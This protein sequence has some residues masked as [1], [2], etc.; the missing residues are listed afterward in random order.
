MSACSISYLSTGR[1]DDATGLVRTR[2][3]ADLLDLADAL[4]DRAQAERPPQL[5][6][7]LAR[8]TGRLRGRRQ[9]HVRA[10]IRPDEHV[11]RRVERAVLVLREGGHPHL[12]GKT[13][14]VDGAGDGLGE[15]LGCHARSP[16][17]AIISA[18]SNPATSEVAVNNIVNAASTP[19]T[20]F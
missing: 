17:L 3:A 16:R 9:A 12:A 8:H 14:R 5:A 13:Q 1:T 19:T 4:A 18:S 2:L 7:Q 11:E 15:L 20:T 6:A 10:G